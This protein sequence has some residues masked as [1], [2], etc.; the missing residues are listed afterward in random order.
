MT[1]R[2]T[3]LHPH[4][5]ARAEGVDLRYP[6]AHE[7]A[8]EIEAAMDRHAV[9]VYLRHLQPVYH[10]IPDDET[11]TALADPVATETMF[12]ADAATHR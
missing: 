1:L 11:G 3:P 7:L 4:I 6:L 5:G 9:L 12:G 2:V 10:L 8:A